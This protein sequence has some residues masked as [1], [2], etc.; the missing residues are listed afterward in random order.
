MSEGVTSLIDGARAN[1]DDLV[2]TLVD[3]ARKGQR[4][5]FNDLARMSGIDDPEPLWKGTRY[6]LHLPEIDTTPVDRNIDPHPVSLDA[7]IEEVRGVVIPD[8]RAATTTTQRDV[9]MAIEHLAE[10]F[11][12]F[13]VAVRD[14]RER[15][16]TPP[17]VPDLDIDPDP[18]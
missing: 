1:A 12:A 11:A 10:V 3:Y 9:L 2:Q 7:I 14:L 8:M 4:D 15:T 13:G 18:A 6:R 16:L 17:L 5:D